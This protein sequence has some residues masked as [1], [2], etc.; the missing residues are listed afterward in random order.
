MTSG[1]NFYLRGTENYLTVNPDSK[2]L[3]TEYLN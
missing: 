2:K 1:I 3:L